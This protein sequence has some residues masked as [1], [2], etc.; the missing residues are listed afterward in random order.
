MPARVA[1]QA[2]PNRWHRAAYRLAL[3]QVLLSLDGLDSELHSAR[4][5]VP[6]GELQERRGPARLRRDGDSY[7]PL[8]ATRLGR[9][10]SGPSLVEARRCDKNRSFARRRMPF[11]R[12]ARV[13]LRRAV[14]ARGLGRAAC[15]HLADR[16]AAAAARRELAGRLL[17]AALLCRNNGHVGQDHHGCC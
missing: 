1:R 5:C 10:T 3:D 11:A 13:A 12:V 6:T 4:S 16:R 14:R 9:Q 7:M 8:G 15:D 2:N 17:G